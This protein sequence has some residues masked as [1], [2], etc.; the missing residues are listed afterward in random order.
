MKQRPQFLKLLRHPRPLLWL[1]LLGC[2]WG[3]CK[4]ETPE[5]LVPEANISPLPALA[6]RDVVLYEVF[7]PDFSAAG[8]FDGMLPRLDSLQQLG[9]NT[10]WLMPLHP[11]HNSP[12]A[13]DDYTAVNRELGDLAAFDRLVAAAHQ[14][15]LRVLLDWVANHTSYYHPWIQQHPDWYTRDINGQIAHPNPQW[16]DVADLNYNQPA[17]R[18]AMMAAMKTW[19]TEH[20]IDGFRCDAADLV[21]D[22]YWQAAI[23]EL[24]QANPNLFFLAEGSQTSH[25]AA[26]FQ[27]TFGW[28]FYNALQ[29]VIINQAP[30]A[31]LAAAHTQEMQSVP[32]GSYRLR[33]T[34]NHD[35]VQQGTPALRFGSE[36]AARAAYVATLAFGAAP[37]VYNG[38]EAGD[39]AQLNSPTRT[40][41]RWSYDPT[42][43]TFYRGLLRVYNA[44]P[45]L[46]YGP[47]EYFDQAP[48]AVV[49]RHRL[50]GQEVVVLVNLRNTA[51]SVPL[52]TTLQ[53]AGWTNSL[54]K[55]P[56]GS[57]ATVPLAAY[58]YAVWQR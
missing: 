57:P 37:L 11:T 58:G 35:E 31:A 6:P 5:Q 23:A 17:L 18:Q 27:L 4:K 9:V 50:N 21:P 52:P 2:L 56:M 55:M 51:V 41:I 14:R 13:V 24:R 7:V 16:T 44:Q 47:A 22:D 42:A 1:L 39:P 34:T 10:L 40:P 19:V 54:T 28:D 26:G 43:A 49:V 20:A 29:R 8:T 48:G 36:A 53:G 46:R 3:G 32:A 38:Q 33:F 12:Y 45:A 15:G 30:A 25:Y